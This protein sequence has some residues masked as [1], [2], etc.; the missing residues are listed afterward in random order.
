MYKTEEEERARR[1]DFRE[2]YLKIK[3]INDQL[4]RSPSARGADVEINK[5]AD[6]NLEDFRKQ[7]TGIRL[8]MKPTVQ[9]VTRR[10]ST[11]PDPIENDSIP[12][13]FDWSE[14]GFVTPV[15]DQSMYLFNV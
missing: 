12:S 5:F 11:K 3:A 10:P 2:N 8:S 15:K 1:A 7:F 14:S 6:R 13:Q 4:K 9:S